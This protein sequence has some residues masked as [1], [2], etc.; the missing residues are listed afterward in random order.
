MLG[1][2]VDKGGHQGDI[3]IRGGVDSDRDVIPF[4]FEELAPQGRL[5]VSEGD[6]VNDTIK[7]FHSEVAQ[8]LRQGSQLVGVGDIE[9]EYLRHR[10][11]FANSSTGDADGT[12]QVR[13]N[14]P[15]ALILGNMDTQKDTPERRAAFTARVRAHAQH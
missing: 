6:G 12:R 2:D 15:G 14:N 4:R 10:I 9:F 3:R 13:N 1:E 11:E 8:L 5:G 7:L